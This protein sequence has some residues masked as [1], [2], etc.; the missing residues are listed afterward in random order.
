MANRL[1]R[2]T[3]AYLLQHQHNPVDWYPWGD[4]AWGRAREL[5]R[6]VLVSI[7]YASCHW[8]HVMERESFEDPETAAR[9]NELLVCIK[10]DREERPDVDQVY[11]DTVV[12]LTGQGGWPLN[13]FCT[14]SGQPFHG[15]T[16]FPPAR[17]HGR[18][19]WT[20]LIGAVADAWRD[21]REAV[22]AQAEELIRAMQRSP[23]VEAARPSGTVALRKAVRELMAS[24]DRTWGGFGSAPKFPTAPNLEAILLADHLGCAPI[25]AFDQLLL[26]LRR[27]ACGGLY[28]QLGG[29]FHRYST[30]ARWQV[31]HFEKMLYDQGQ[32]LRVYSE[33]HRQARA[34]D[35]EVD[36]E[37][38]VAETIRFL[39]REMRGDA[40]NLYASLDADSE[41]HEGRFYVWTP[42]EVQ[43][44][45]GPEDGREFC[46]AYA[47][48]RPGNFEGGDASVL[49]HAL[50]GDRPRFRES[51]ERLLAARARRTRPA[52]DAKGVASWMGYAISGLATAG[53]AFEHREWVEAAARTAEFVLGH[54]RG[55]DGALRRIWDGEHARIPAFLDD[56]AALQAGLLDLHRADSDERWIEFSG[57]FGQLRIG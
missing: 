45:L 18:P 30:D 33:A 31:P 25:G 53:A 22:E 2:E 13:V 15:G 44:A 39:E 54:L 34:A 10:V 42:D 48:E 11:M 7:G 14:P 19:S 5:D 23:S 40:G 24:A 17:A 36:L 57:G 43:A 1:A 8:C 21:R 29:G 9:M 3:S 55:S 52:T 46:S 50:A 6:P 27:M 49:Q 35:L 47:V 20:E 56:F 51:R 16:Y 38:P 4:E 26:T 28:D 41:G 37:W 12:R 32:L